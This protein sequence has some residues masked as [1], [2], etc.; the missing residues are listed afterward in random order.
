MF[1]SDKPNERQHEPCPVCEGTVYCDEKGTWECDTCEFG[2]MPTANQFEAKIGS[3]L[4]D[5]QI[6]KEAVENIII[7]A[8]TRRKFTERFIMETYSSQFAY[9]TIKEGFDTFKSVY[10][11]AYFIAFAALADKE[12]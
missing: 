10:A 5:F 4:E 8:M 1:D 7:E 3:D 6:Y 11:T 2:Y 9:E 12:D